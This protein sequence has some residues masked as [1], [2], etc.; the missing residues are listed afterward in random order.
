MPSV[1]IQTDEITA[2]ASAAFDYEFTGTT[3]FHTPQIPKLPHNYKIGLIVGPS[4]SGKTLALNT[5]GKPKDP[6]W[7]PNKAIISHFPDFPTAV[8]LLSAVGLNSIPVWLKPHHVLSTGE[9]AR[10][11][12]ARNLQSGSV[13]D[14]FTSTV[15]RQTARSLAAS[16][17][18]HADRTDI[19]HLTFASCHR[20][21]IPWLDPD[22]T[23]DTLSQTLHVGR[24]LQCRQIII[25]VHRCDWHYWRTFRTHHYL[26]HSIHKGA[27]CYLGT[28]L[29][30]PVVFTAVLA[31]PHPKLKDAFREHRSVVIPEHQG[32]G[33]GT[34]FV[35]TIA[36]LYHRQGKRFYSRTIHPRVG[37]HRQNSPKWTPTPSNLKKQTH[38]K[39]ITQISD[40]WT[41][42]TTRIC[43]S[44]RYTG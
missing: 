27:Q 1:Q 26:T 8:K 35:D 36:E 38:P 16:I 31:L 3:H 21:L 18:E 37:K 23:F 24:S 34:A 41:T 9:R 6:T 22:W 29:E 42:D 30:T 13:F 43:Y 39:A 40:H 28:W 15:D 33:I 14:E 2:Q 10:V 20:D 7:D 17:R 44:H 12:I 19:H 11:D 5:I 25:R 4:G 32:L